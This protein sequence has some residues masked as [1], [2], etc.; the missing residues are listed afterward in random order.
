MA[1]INPFVK[2]SWDKLALACVLYK[3]IVWTTANIV[4]YVIMVR[5]S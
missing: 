5:G 2:S 4:G 1:L 3:R